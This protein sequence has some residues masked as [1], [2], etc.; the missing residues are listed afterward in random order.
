MEDRWRKDRLTESQLTPVDRW[1]N[2]AYCA[3]QRT[4]V[5]ELELPQ[6]R[7]RTRDTVAAFENSPPSPAGLAP[8]HKPRLPLPPSPGRLRETEVSHSLCLPLPRGFGQPN[9]RTLFASLSRRPRLPPRP[10]LPCLPLLGGSGFS[11]GAPTSYRLPLL[12]ASGFA[13]GALL[14]FLGTILDSFV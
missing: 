2:A 6:A 14:L 11:P 8:I 12:R 5:N 13:P 10:P 7:R 3:C 1:I 9:P 4:G